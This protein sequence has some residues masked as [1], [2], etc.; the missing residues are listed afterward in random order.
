MTGEPSVCVYFKQDCECIAS[1]DCKGQEVQP[2]QEF[3]Q[4]TVFILVL[5]VDFTEIVVYQL[6]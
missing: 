4:Q 5:M 2:E 3:K 1:E 6:L